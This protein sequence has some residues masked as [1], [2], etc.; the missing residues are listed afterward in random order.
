MKHV[1]KF[2]PT[3]VTVRLAPVSERSEELEM[4]E[5]GVINIGDGA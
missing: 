1:S 2:T 5:H 3:G 4:W